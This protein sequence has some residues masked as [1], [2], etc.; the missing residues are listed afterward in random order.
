MRTRMDAI[1]TGQWPGHPRR[2]V[3]IVAN[4]AAIDS[5]APPSVPASPILIRL[6]LGSVES[7]SGGMSVTLMEATAGQ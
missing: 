5:F 1:E 4:K 3:A 2:R 7:R 6:G